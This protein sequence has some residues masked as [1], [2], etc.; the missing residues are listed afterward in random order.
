MFL[1]VET[2]AQFSFS[3]NVDHTKT[4]LKFYE[5]RYVTNGNKHKRTSDKQRHMYQRVSSPREH[6]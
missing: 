4:K 2:K 5:T 6:N 1:Y 3:V